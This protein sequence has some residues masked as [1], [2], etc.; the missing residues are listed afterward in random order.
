MS[1]PVPELDDPLLL[2]QVVEGIYRSA[3]DGRE[4]AL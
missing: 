3:A 1:D 2:H 4:V